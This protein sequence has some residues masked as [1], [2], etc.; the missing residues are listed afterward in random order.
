MLSFLPQHEQKRILG[1]YRKRVT[2]VVLFFV[3]I[4]SLLALI[5]LA[6]S[7]YLTYSQQTVLEREYVSV[8]AENAD[9]DEGRP[10]EIVS[11]IRSQLRLANILPE[12]TVLSNV[13]AALTDLPV[14]VTLTEIRY[15]HGLDAT[16]VLVG[17]ATTRE[18]L[19][20]YTKT[21]EENE[22]F[23]EVELP[24]SYLAEDT[25]LAFQITLT[26][27]MDADNEDSNNDA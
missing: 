21:L 13:A 1:M 24:I 27:D 26:L 10:L 6:P 2:T 18:A 20:G 5:V 14:A 17:H 19:L 11:K 8:I 25:D 4:L 23:M 9:A 12:N 3:A 22:L 16:I 7:Y 15:K